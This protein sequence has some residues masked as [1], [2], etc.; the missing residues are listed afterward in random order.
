[1][2]NGVGGRTVAE[3]QERLSVAEADRW[4]Q[5]MAKRG[6]LHVGMRLEAGFALLAAMINRAIGGK[7]EVNDF[8][9]HV[10]Q[11]ATLDDVMKLLSGG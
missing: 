1:V 10:E 8:M 4:Q 7:A 6:S 5:Y 11:E 9:P 2:L 3:A